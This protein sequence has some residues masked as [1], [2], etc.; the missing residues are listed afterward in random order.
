MACALGI[1]FYNDA[2]AA[3]ETDGGLLAS[4]T[5]SK[6][7]TFGQAVL[8]T[9][10][11]QATYLTTATPAGLSRLQADSAGLGIDGDRQR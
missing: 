8:L 11:E 6:Q 4:R 10:G 5:T 3:I 2:H 1:S 7:Q 9:G